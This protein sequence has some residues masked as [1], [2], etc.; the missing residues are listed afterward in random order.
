MNDYFAQAVIDYLLGNVTDRVFEEFESNL[1]SADPGMSI[2]K[3]RQNAIDVSVKIVIEDHR[4][5]LRGGWALLTPNYPNTLRTLP[6]EESIL[7]ITNRAL[8]SARFDWSTE[9]VKSFERIALDSIIGAQTGVYITSTFTNTDTDARHNVGLVIR[10]KPGKANIVRRNT[11]SMS[12]TV[13]GADAAGSQGSASRILGNDGDRDVQILAFK[14]PIDRSSIAGD[15]GIRDEAPSMS[16]T[17]VIKSIAEE[18]TNAIGQKRDEFVENKDIIN[19]EE[20]RKSVGLL[21]QFSYSLKRF[22]WA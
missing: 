4:E 16:E 7:L 10:Y 19:L 15:H 1:A 13:E 2:S 5:E 6:L 18:L 14:A 11:R 20:A 8:Y 9:K 17:A 3:I 21:E 12:T 22:V